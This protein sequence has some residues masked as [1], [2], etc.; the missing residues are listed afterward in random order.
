MNDWRRE[1]LNFVAT[2]QHWIGG[3]ED[4]KNIKADFLVLH[5]MLSR[6]QFDPTE[7]F[8]RPVEVRGTFNES[9]TSELLNS[10]ILK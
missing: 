1:K 4:N 8:R 3:K 10:E 7:R 5:L 2:L 9:K 6:F